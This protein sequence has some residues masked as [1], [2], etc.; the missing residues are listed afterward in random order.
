M[1]QY[2]PWSLRLVAATVTLLT[3]ERAAAIKIRFSTKAMQQM[4]KDEM[5]W[6]PYSARTLYSH[7]N[8]LLCISQP[9][10]LTRKIAA[11][12]LCPQA[13]RTT[14]G[15]HWGC[16]KAAANELRKKRRVQT[17][18]C[19]EYV[20]G[21]VLRAAPQVLLGAKLCVRMWISG[22]VRFSYS[23]SSHCELKLVSESSLDRW[24]SM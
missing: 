20:G 19:G 8:K 18:C 14:D 21:C 22:T 1:Q 13:E 4:Q 9:H 3:F 5:A 23:N 16:T 2:K 17:E 12:D 15:L 10:S 6:M 7:R 24:W 11:N